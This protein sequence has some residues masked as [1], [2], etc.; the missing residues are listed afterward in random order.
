MNQAITEAGIAAAQQVAAWV[1]PVARA[2]YAAKGVVYGLVGGLAV[3][4]ATASG[5]AEGTVGALASLRGETGGRLLLLLIAA[6]LVG[7]VVWRVV[8]ALLDPE[9]PGVRNPK[10]VGMRIFYFL[11][12]LV[13]GS[14]AATAWQLSRGLHANAEDSHVIWVARL[15]DKPLEDIIGEYGRVGH[16]APPLIRKFVLP[17]AVRA[18]AMLSLYRMNITHATLFPD[19]DGLA[20]SIG[21]ELEITWP[22]YGAGQS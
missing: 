3:K 13:Y 8:Q 10:R 12:A 4:A 7:H 6:G 11:S 17:P 20:R 22:G 2:G 16:G 15:L 19:L 21:Y 5:N 9:H 18:E 1:P 14:M